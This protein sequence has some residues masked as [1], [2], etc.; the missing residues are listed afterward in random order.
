MSELEDKQ[1]ENSLN[2]PS[3]T[4]PHT[5]SPYRRIHASLVGLQLVSWFLTRVSFS[6]I[7]A[8][9]TLGDSEAMDEPCL[10]SHCSYSF[11]VEM[12]RYPPEAS[13]KTQR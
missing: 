12:Y 11:E 9:W 7:S 2:K 3:P 4:H 13:Q 10:T 8:S 1:G 5:P 6:P